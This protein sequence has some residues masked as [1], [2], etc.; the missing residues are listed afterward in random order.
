MFDRLDDSG[1]KRVLLDGDRFGLVEGRLVEKRLDRVYL[2]L[3]LLA[4]RARS[5]E[6]FLRLRESRIRRKRG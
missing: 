4:R 3:R 2:A 6:V 1:E 5:V